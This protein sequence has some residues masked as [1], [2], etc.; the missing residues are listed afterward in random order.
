MK[1]NGKKDMFVMTTVEGLGDYLRDRFKALLEFTCLD[2]TTEDIPELIAIFDKGL[3]DLTERTSIQLSGFTDREIKE[4]AFPIFHTAIMGFY[5][6]MISA[7]K[8]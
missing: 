8:K 7:T 4:F 1:K 2:H 6:G 5:T 3:K